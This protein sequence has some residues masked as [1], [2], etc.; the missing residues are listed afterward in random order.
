MNSKYF[1]FLL[2]LVSLFVGGCGSGKVGL[3]GKVTFSDDGSPLT[4]G[5]VWF[6]TG[7]FS[8]RGDLTD[9]G[10]YTIGSIAQADGLPPG[11]YQV[12]VSGAVKPEPNDKGGMPKMLPLIDEKFT[13][14]KSSGLEVE[15]TSSLKNF[16]FKVDRAK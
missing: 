4:V 9:N 14:A 7:N 1:G 15:V 11:K 8:A 3:G 2:L 6:T 12:Y 13:S 5:T 16:D 10:A